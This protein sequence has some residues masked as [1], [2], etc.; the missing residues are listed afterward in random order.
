MASCA[1]ANKVDGYRFPSEETYS[2]VEYLKNDLREP[3]TKFFN[4]TS[5]QSEDM[6]F[7]D[8]YGYAD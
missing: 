6:S 3:F 4:L 1:Y 8:L 7:M 5:K 2:D